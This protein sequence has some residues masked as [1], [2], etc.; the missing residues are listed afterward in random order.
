V[1][2][3]LQG[4]TDEAILARIV[5]I[6]SGVAKAD[7]AEDP[8]LAEYQLLASGRALI[9][10]ASPDAHLHAETLTR[11][12]WDLDRDPELAGVGA[13]VAVHRLREV[14]CIYGFTRFEPAPLANDD[15]E[16]VGLAVRG[17]PLGRAPTGCRG[18][19]SSA[20]GSSSS[21]RPRRWRD[22][23]VGRPFFGAPSN[24]RQASGNGLRRS[25]P[26]AQASARPR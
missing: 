1:R 15:L 3:N 5:S 4:Y 25:A 11:D 9:G 13:I 24:S 7:E 20:R 6:A 26:Q 21:S 10:V 14:A 12:V 22:G 18:S 2:A 16:D 8:K 17:A 19:S 23:S